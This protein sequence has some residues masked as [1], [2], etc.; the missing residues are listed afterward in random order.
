MSIRDLPK[1]EIQ[2]RIDRIRWYHEFDFGDGLRA[3]VKTPDA[4]S[5]RA[6]WRFIRTE[7]DK[8]DFAQKSVLDIGCWDGYWS[9]YAE[10]RNAARV[11]A[12]DD[13]GQNWAG[14]AGFALARELLGSAVESE[15]QLSVYD[16][17]K[18]GR[19]FDIVLC[20]GVYYHLFDPFYDRLLQNPFFRESKRNRMQC[21][22]ESER[23]PRSILQVPHA[24]AQIRHCCH[25]DTIVVFEGD[26]FF[27]LIG[28]PTQ[29]AA[30]FSRNV[31]QA[32]RFVPDPDTLRLLINATYFTI[33]SEAIHPLSDPAPDGA[34]RGVNRILLVCRPCRCANECH[35]Y[36]PP[37]GLHQYDERSALPAHAWSSLFLGS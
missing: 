31:R 32:P 29:S 20:L 9:F 36:R 6:M 12:T 7:L 33:A 17:E 16:L 22:Y 3:E 13:S 28:S 11:F 10:R 24:F 35:E 4:H 5:H 14:G 15:L 19:K 27:G 2:K 18:L 30:L 21:E 23:E 8:I 25:P 34:P 26:V 1:A 37:F